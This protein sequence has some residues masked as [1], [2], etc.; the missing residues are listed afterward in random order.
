MFK[1]VYLPSDLRAAPE[2]ASLATWDSPCPR[3][4]G[5]NA[6]IARWGPGVPGEKCGIPRYLCWNAVFV[7]LS[8]GS[9]CY[10]IC[11]NEFTLTGMGDIPWEQAM[12]AIYSSW[13]ALQN[14][15]GIQ[16]A[17]SKSYVFYIMR[18]NLV[19]SLIYIMPIFKEIEPRRLE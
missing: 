2:G 15:S 11:E 8:L 19:Q 9:C 16:T 3:D 4:F 10:H 18:S 5:R 6:K 14:L 7:R 12:T 1:A 17:Y 13:N